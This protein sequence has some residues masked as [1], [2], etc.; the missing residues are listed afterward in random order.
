MKDETLAFLRIRDWL[1]K[2]IERLTFERE[3][4][5]HALR[6]VE[7]LIAIEEAFKRG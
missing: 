5:E 3:V 2:R 4:A 6:G 7:T 1:E